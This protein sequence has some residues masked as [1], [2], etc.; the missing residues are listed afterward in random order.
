MWGRGRHLLIKSRCSQ[1]QES[2]LIVSSGSQRRF[3]DQEKQSDLG[4]CQ[5]CRFWDLTSDLLNQKVWVE[6]S[7]VLMNLLGDFHV[8][9]SLRTTSLELLQSLILTNDHNKAKITD[10]RCRLQCSLCVLLPCLLPSKTAIRTAICVPYVVNKK[11]QANK[12]TGEIVIFAKL[13]RKHK[14]S[15][16]QTIGNLDLDHFLLYLKIQFPDHSTVVSRNQ[17]K[18]WLAQSQLSSPVLAM[19]LFFFFH[20]YFHLDVA[21]LDH[22]SVLVEL[23]H[24]THD[25]ESCAYWMSHSSLFQIIFIL[26]LSFP[27]FLS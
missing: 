7:N 21:S 22:S 1:S 19:P 2:P 3:W 5:K 14:P 25:G 10:S 12:S 9:R 24:L 26:T 17:C 4:T 15:G 8:W 11:C 23:I 20:R 27:P 18:T 16:V 6:Y 13:G